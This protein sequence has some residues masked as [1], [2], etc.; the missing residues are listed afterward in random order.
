LGGTDE[1][2][3]EHQ[4]DIAITPHI[5]QGF[6][7]DPLM[8]LRFIAAAH[9]D[10]ALHRLGRPLTLDDLSEHRHLVIRDTAVQQTRDSGGWLGADQRWTV[11]HKATQIAAAC[12]GLGFA[13]FPEDAIRPELDQGTL[14]PLPMREGGERFGQVYLIF[15]DP[16]FPTPSAVRMAE[17]LREDLAALC[18]LKD[19]EMPD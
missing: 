12:L 8:R 18:P 4:V 3:Y 14:K 6:M 10:H 11:S 2:L 17:I 13:W 9:P 1:A 16:D 15:A 19:R 7:G 5:P